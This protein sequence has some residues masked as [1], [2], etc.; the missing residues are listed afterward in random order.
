MRFGERVRQLRLEKGMTQS[1]LAVPLDVSM[2]YICKVENEKL[3]SGDYP[4]EKFIHRL[5]AELKADEDDLMMLAGKVPKGIRKQIRRRPGLF[6]ALAKLDEQSL[7]RLTNKL[8]N[9]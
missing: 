8:L 4:S 2:S 7:D 6:Q 1:E 3:S 9:K 5:A